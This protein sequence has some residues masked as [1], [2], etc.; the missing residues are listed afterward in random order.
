M[1]D[2]K[3]TWK[4]TCSFN[5]NHPSSNPLSN[6]DNSQLNY[7]SFCH[8]SVFSLIVFRDAA[9]M[10]EKQKKAEERQAAAGGAKK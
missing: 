4:K 6:L 8:Q 2:F 3:V 9:M 1:E 5:G 7:F 10:R